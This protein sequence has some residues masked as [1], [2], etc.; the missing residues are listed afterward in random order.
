MPV[1]VAD[2]YS[3]A[4]LINDQRVWS[5]KECAE[6]FVKSVALLKN[7]LSVEAGEDG[8][9]I[10]D[11]VGFHIDFI[12]V[13]IGL[14]LCHCVI[15][16]CLLFMNSNV[17]TLDMPVTCHLFLPLTFSQ[18]RSVAYLMAGK[19]EKIE[20][21]CHHFAANDMNIEQYEDIGT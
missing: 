12:G 14:A 17:E 10:W 21:G 18:F 11:K 20:I 1:I 7:Q 5:I 15:V 6:V 4:G 19:A 16:Q 8:V 2:G 3:A 13:Y 9:L